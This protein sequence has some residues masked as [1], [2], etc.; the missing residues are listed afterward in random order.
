M[1]RARMS[2][3]SISCQPETLEECPPVYGR[4]KS[5]FTV[6]TD[7]LDTNGVS[8]ET[9]DHGSTLPSESR[10]TLWTWATGD[11]TPPSMGR[12]ADWRRRGGF[13]SRNRAPARC[14]VGWNGFTPLA[15]LSGFI[16]AL[17]LAALL[18]R[19]GAPGVPCGEGEALTSSRGQIRHAEGQTRRVPPGLGVEPLSL[20]GTEVRDRLVGAYNPFQHRLCTD[21]FIR[22]IRA[23]PFRNHQR[24]MAC[25]MGSRDGLGRPTH[26]C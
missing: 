8:F 7:S 26:K 25:C 5:G 11:P 14:L 21:E 17:S 19:G 10:G 4:L 22:S 23:F 13:N 18:W 1:R 12:G 16:L 20:R 24:V 15:A 9:A 6:L 2:G 3:I